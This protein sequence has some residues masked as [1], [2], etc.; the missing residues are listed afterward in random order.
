MSDRSEH[1]GLDPVDGDDLDDLAD[2]DAEDDLDA[3]DLL[4]GPSDEVREQ[5]A[6]W[7]R[8]RSAPGAPCAFCGEGCEDH[9]FGLAVCRRCTRTFFQ[10]GERMCSGA[11]LHCEVC[12]AVAV[13]VVDAHPLC[14]SCH[15]PISVGVSHDVAGLALS[16]TWH[17][18]RNL[19]TTDDGS[20]G[21]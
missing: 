17:Q 2:D 7:Q 8:A 13:Q 5:L 20:G 16:T 21:D 11:D 15:A 18:I 6:E 9:L 1:D 4:P 14:A 19:E 12:G 3:D 10:L